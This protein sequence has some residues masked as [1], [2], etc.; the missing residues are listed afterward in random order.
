MPRLYVIQI[1]NQRQDAGDAEADTKVQSV[2]DFASSR[3]DLH[4]V[5]RLRVRVHLSVDGVLS[6]VDGKIHCV[7]VVGGR[8]KLESARKLPD[9]SSVLSASGIRQSPTRK[10]CTRRE[11]SRTPCWR[12]TTSTDVACVSNRSSQIELL[13]VLNKITCA[14]SRASVRFLLINIIQASTNQVIQEERIKNQSNQ[15]FPFSCSE[16]RFGIR[17]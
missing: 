2:R 8:L 12:P 17:N 3:H 15:I 6:A 10:F 5:R 14:A 11:Q 16:T 7:C 1:P 9:R 13:F 4:F